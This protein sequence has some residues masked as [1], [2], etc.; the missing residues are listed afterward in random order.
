[1]ARKPTTLRTIINELVD[2]TN[3]DTQRIRVLEQRE[4]SLSF[5]I[6][7][8]EQEALNINNAIQ[9]LSSGLDSE[10][11]KRDKGMAEVQNTVKE[12][13]K[14]LKRLATSGKVKELEAMLDLYNPLKSNFMTRAEVEQL[15]SKRLSGMPKNNK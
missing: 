5:R 13:I 1:M 8:M 11:K 3:T 10:L 12:I 9:K 4:E 2:R 15:I 14:Q 6:N 7:A